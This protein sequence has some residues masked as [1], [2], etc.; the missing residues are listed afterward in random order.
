[1]LTI[2]RICT[3][4]AALGLASCGDF[5]GSDSCTLIGCTSGLNVVLED[6]T[7][8]PY[9]V[10]VYSGPS[11]TRY[12]LE[13]TANPCAQI[14]FPDFTPQRVFA[15]VIRPNQ[16]TR[17]YEVIPSYSESRPNGGN[18]PPLCR[19][20]TIRLPSDALVVF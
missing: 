2:L 10:E 12:V 18:C 20:A 4:V 6:V 11:T 16:L 14:F 3:A 19:N 17:R 7:S 1:L 13:C 5:L 8:A 9:R 15:E